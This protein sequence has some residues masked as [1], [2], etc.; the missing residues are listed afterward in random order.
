M[1]LDNV[2]SHLA[3]RATSTHQCRRLNF[4]YVPHSW[5]LDKEKNIYVLKKLK[6]KSKKREWAPNNNPTVIHKRN[7]LAEP[8]TPPP[9]ALKSILPFLMIFS[10]ARLPLY[11]NEVAGLS[12][13]GLQTMKEGGLPAWW[14]IVLICQNPPSLGKREEREGGLSALGFCYC[15]FEFSN[16]CSLSIKQLLRSFCWVINVVH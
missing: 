9:A 13:V 2:F 3:F 8:L 15:L 5:Y 6:K 10:T 1:L 12:S 11:G 14:T 7:V 16:P 4:R